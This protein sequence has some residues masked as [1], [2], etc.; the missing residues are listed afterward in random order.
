[1]LVETGERVGIG[2]FIVTGSAPK[3]VIVR[4]IGPSLTPFGVPNAMADPTLEL[5]GPAG[6]TTITNNNWRDTQEAE[7]QA[8]GLAPTDNLESAIVA[9]LAPGNY[10]AIVAGNNNTTGVALVEVYDLNASNGSKLAN[11][12]TRAFV[13]TGG[14]IVIAGFIL[15]NSMVSDQVIIRGIGPSLT[16]IGVTDALADPTLELRNSNGTLLVSNNNWQDN[17]SQAAIIS[18]AGLAPSNPM[19]SAIARTL[20]PGQYTALLAGLN[21]GTGTGLV[22]VYD[23]G[24]GTP[25]GPSPTPGT[26]TP[27]ATATATVG[28][29]PPPPSPTP[30]SSPSPSAGPPCVENFDGV[31]APALPPG[32]VATNPDPGDGSMWVTSISSPNSAPNCAFVPDQ[33]GISDKVLDRMTVNVTSASATISWRNN[34]NTEFSDGI[35]WD[36]Y[37]LEV[38]SPNISGGDFLDITDSHVGGSFVSGGYTGEIDGTANNPLAGRMAWSADSGGYIDTAINLG[39]NLVG[40]TVTF[41][42]RMG[43]DEAVA[44]P[45]VRMDNIAFTGASCP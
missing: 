35:F 10:T 17:P 39:P 24:N 13:S 16:A 28:G 45:G 1:M 29:T 44:A 15:G 43:T 42:F 33:D 23:L 38:S 18:A 8:T 19:E 22:E 2:G 7:I 4:A 5:H 34:F 20:S 32:W 12:S 31:T 14:N 40:Q 41:R 30:S 36:G 25:P 21:D 26:P 3:Q 9:S 27:T 37:V 6:F 11:I